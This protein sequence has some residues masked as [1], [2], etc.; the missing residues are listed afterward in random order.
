M[1]H[2]WIGDIIILDDYHSTPENIIQAS[3][4]TSR[5]SKFA[6]I[7]EHCFDYYING[8]TSKEL[9]RFLSNRLLKYWFAHR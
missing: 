3:N 6:I 1:R 5:E 2:T 8:I 9:Q 4:D 7:A